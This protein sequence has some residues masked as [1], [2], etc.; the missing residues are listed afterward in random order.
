MM[1]QK[2]RIK[3]DDIVDKNDVTT[4]LKKR[5]GHESSQK[6]RRRKS[7]SSR[8]SSSDSED[9]PLMSSPPKRV[10]VAI[11]ELF[12]T[13]HILQNELGISLVTIRKDD[14][15]ESLLS[16]L[17]GNVPDIR[18]STE[19]PQYENDID[20][21]S[22][23][24]SK[25]SRNVPK[26]KEMMYLRRND[27]DVIADI[28]EIIIA[29]SKLYISSS[30]THETVGESVLTKAS[31]I[32]CSCFMPPDWKPCFVDLKMETKSTD[33]DSQVM[34]SRT[35][36]GYVEHPAVQGL[37]MLLK[38]LH[39]IDTFGPAL[40]ELQVD[41]EQ[42]FLETL[43][44]DLD[45]HFGGLSERNDRMMAFVGM[46]NRQ[47]MVRQL[48]ASLQR[49]LIQNWGC[50]DR[51]NLFQAI[52]LH[53]Q[54]D[55]GASPTPTSP[56]ENFKDGGED[57]VGENHGIPF[58]SKSSSRLST[59][60][61]R[62]ILARIVTSLLLHRQNYCVA[63]HLLYSYVI[64]TMPSLGMEDYPCLPPVLSI[65]V[66][67]SMLV[68]PHP[69]GRNL[70]EILVKNAE[71]ESLRVV[72]ATTAAVF[73]IRMA[74]RDSR[75]SG[76]AIV[77]LAAYRRLKYLFGSHMN[78][79]Q[80][81]FSNFASHE[82]FSKVLFMNQIR[83][84]LESY[85]S[86]LSEI[87]S[88][89]V[90]S[91]TMEHWTTPL[92]MTLEADRAYLREVFFSF[93]DQ[94]LEDLSY[95]TLRIVLGCAKACR[96]MEACNIERHRRRS[97][98]RPSSPE[99]LTSMSAG[100]S[101]Y[102][103]DG[104]IREST[105]LVGN[106]NKSVRKDLDGFAKVIIA[107]CLEL[108][109]GE[110]IIRLL[111]RCSL[112]G[113]FVS[114]TAPKPPTVARVINLER[115]KDRMAAF[116]ASV[117]A[118]TGIVVVR[119][120]IPPEHWEDA[121]CGESDDPGFYR[122]LIGTYA[123][124]GS[125]K[126]GQSNQRLS[127]WSSY[128]GVDSL[129]RAKWRPYDIRVFDDFASDDPNYLVSLTPSEKACALSHLSTWKGVASILPTDNSS[130]SKVSIASC[131][132]S[133]YARGPSM[134]GSSDDGDG[135]GASS[136]LPSV[137]VALILEDDAILV[138]RFAERLDEILAEIPRDFHYCAIGYS[139]PKT[140]PLVDM[141]PPCKHIKLPTMTWY[142]TGYLLS[143]AGARYLL[144]QL[145]VEGP[146]DTWIGRMML[147]KNWENEYGSRV[148]IGNVLHP[149]K[150]GASSNEKVVVSRNELKTCVKFRAFCASIP[151]C[152]QKVGQSWQQKDSDIVYSGKL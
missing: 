65:C 33:S 118:Q 133:G 88:P 5:S 46:R 61:E 38:A 120:V 136:G 99:T 97:S 115:R 102:L 89:S 1:K 69:S 139:R 80:R 24:N 23:S 127:V 51:R 29:W 143:A 109:D 117:I 27:E 132:W 112:G 84:I 126:G 62:S 152:S 41:E 73:R 20:E 6:C 34:L 75:I 111:L 45:D 60:S 137:P 49:D 87:R 77:E 150:R 25:Q 59:I 147:E 63:L 64:S 140:A 83:C 37:S 68:T 43:S 19:R 40:D 28:L 86:R 57:D 72:L 141:S 104:F 66:V 81:K 146:V 108:G 11:L 13:Q 30:Q 145:P 8:S 52:S 21:V 56:G 142:L 148:G 16:I 3:D 122:A 18:N 48:I 70:L 113:S 47:G 36:E 7:S 114:S 76:L 67:E 22:M 42:I 95:Q 55:D 135:I 85:F 58:D 134:F 110:G 82:R 71:I 35:N 39:C 130:M 96:R 105:R 107:V 54:E 116:M 119:G 4:T 93:V 26:G 94:F 98:S 129:L 78:I 151:L 14:D 53:F 12:R 92:L 2:N 15:G 91:D 101:S 144:R 90:A 17:D 123:V 32:K 106:E 50:Q 128:P 121:V 125:K 9:P 124:D 10:R 79:K 131:T 74:S 149:G 31:R 138:D 44:P 103:V 100:M